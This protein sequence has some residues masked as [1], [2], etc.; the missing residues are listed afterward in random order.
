[1]RAGQ[2]GSALQTGQAVV[3]FMSVLGPTVSIELLHERELIEAVI[4][5]K[6][7]TQLDLEVGSRCRIRL[8]LPTIFPEAE[9]DQEKVRS[10]PTKPRR[11]RWLSRRRR[12]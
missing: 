7:L 8:R 10:E 5:R 12:K 1:L 9:V 11:L 4:S 2:F 3:R 6:Q